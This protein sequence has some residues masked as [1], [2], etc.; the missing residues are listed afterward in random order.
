[1]RSETTKATFSFAR[2]LTAA[3][4]VFV[5][6]SACGGDPV[7]DT[8]EAAASAPAPIL[9][10]CADV[11]FNSG[12]LAPGGGLPVE[13]HPAGAVLAALIERGGADGLDRLPK[14]DWRLAFATPVRADFVAP[15]G[16]S[17]SYVSF[18][19][20]DGGWE[21]KA[22]GPCAGKVVV[23]SLNV[24]SWELDLEDV[25]GFGPASTSLKVHVTEQACASGQPLGN[26]LHE[27]RISYGPSEIV[28]QFVAD[29]L[30]GPQDCPGNPSILA[31]IE[32][33]EPIGE[34]KLLDGSVFPPAERFWGFGDD[35]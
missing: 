33:A 27:P 1:M 17:W 15:A 9:V 11:P 32:L 18:V 21:A 25:A 30:P 6:A 14:S 10:S 29:P 26:R 23:P 2:P 34:R 5:A 35:N 4:M 16:D 20:A 28:I 13:A 22:W 19:P 3:I 31:P 8:P 24:A 7:S 12:V